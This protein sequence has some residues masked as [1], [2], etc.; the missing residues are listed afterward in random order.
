MRGT[1]NACVKT[2]AK[3]R[4]STNA[5]DDLRLLRLGECEARAARVA[6]LA[7]AMNSAA[8]IVIGS[9]S[10][11]G[12]APSSSSGMTRWRSC[13][14]AISPAITPPTITPTMEMLT[15]FP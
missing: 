10:S 2:D 4:M 8:K 7:I 9:T 6:A 3:T 5:R 1:E 11:G 15:V 12:L 13:R 14:L